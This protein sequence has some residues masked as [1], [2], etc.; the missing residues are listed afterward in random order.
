MLNNTS[1]RR[2]VS[3]V[4]EP[5]ARGL[6]RLHISPDAVTFVGTL[7]TCA[8]ALVFFP[9]ESWFMGAL[10]ITIFVVSDLIDGT[11]ARLSGRSG[12]WGAFLDSTLD[13]VADGA[14]FGAMILGLTHAGDIRTAW[15]ALACLVGGGVVSYAKA[16][17]GSLGVECNVGVAERPERILIALV[18]AGLYG[19]GIPYL[20]P[21]ALWV[22]AVLTWFT[23]FQRVMHV[24]RQMRPGLGTDPT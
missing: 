4:V 13:R 1:V 22:L 23:V 24:R 14:I 21:A 7:G 6:L 12:P 15:V 16:R 19:L 17:A 3:V 9:R 5:V 10:V 8:A 18:A 2:A 20:L 11:M